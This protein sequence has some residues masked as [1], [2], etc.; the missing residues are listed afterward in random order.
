VPIPSLRD[1]LRRHG[2]QATDAQVDAALVSLERQ[3]AIDL[4]VAQSPVT[5]PD[6]HRGIERPG[7]GL[8]YYVSPRSS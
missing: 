8:A 1:E 3:Y 6:R 7:R 5:L 2:V 4:L